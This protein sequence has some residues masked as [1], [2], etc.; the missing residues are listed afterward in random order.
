[1]TE[2]ELSI[3]IVNWNGKSF[4]PD[5]LK[6]IVE[7]PPRAS[8]EVVVVDNASTDGSAEWLRSDEYTGMMEKTICHVLEPGAN[9][10]FGPGS[11]LAIAATTAP[12]ILILNPDTRILPGAIDRLI[13]TLRSESRIGMVGPKLYNDDGSLQPSVMR[14]PPSP[15]SIIVEGLQLD[16]VLPKRVLANWLFGNHWE[17][18]ERRAVPVIAGAAMICKREMI[19]QVGGFDPSI[20]MYS[21]E[22]EWC[23]R[24]RRK[25]WQVYFEPLAGIIHSRGKSTGQR[26][27][28]D[29]QMLV[30]ERATMYFENKSFS[31]LRNL[32]NGIARL[33]VLSLH[34]LRWKLQGRDVSVFVDLIKMH[35]DNCKNLLL[36]ENNAAQREAG[37]SKQG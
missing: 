33:F 30:V 29:E 1:M 6:S 25:G 22:F 24:A 18:N 15:A 8:Y 31:K 28:A 14:Q 13:E 37:E 3:V 2:P 19:D 20:H 35:V 36:T 4:L 5:C 34:A 27:S 9:L 32:L 17:H 23:V 21:E 11:N 7:N 12:N 26:W 16:R 10:G